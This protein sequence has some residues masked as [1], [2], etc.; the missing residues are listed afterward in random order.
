MTIAPQRAVVA[1]GLT[2]R[3]G[4]VTALDGVDLEI[5]FG[6]V[7]GLLGHNG[8]GKTT[9]V[10]ILTTLLLPTD[11][12]AEV[13][14][15]DVVREPA[16]V[17]E[18]IALAGQ[19]ATL[20]ELLTGRENLVL[21]GCLLGLSRRDAKAR[22]AELLERFGLADAAD[23]VCG[24]YSGGMRRRLDLAACLLVPRPFVVLDEPTT[25]LD[26]ASRIEVWAAV[27]EL[28]DDGTALLLTTQYLE[29]A[30][31]LADRVVVLAGGRVVA[32]GTPSA[33]KDR[34]GGRRVEA[35]LSDAALV[36]AARDALVAAG[37]DAAAEHR[38]CT[39][40]A[41]APR[42]SLD[43]EAALE[44]LRGADIEP[45]EAGL[46]RPTLDDAFLALA[47]EQV[48]DEAVAAS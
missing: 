32:E 22:A 37:L 40:S 6:R 43:L 12:R 27:R 11:G 26:P 29:E 13:C 30:D 1:S 41:P 20:D 46:R 25:G 48:L 5:E 14:G 38:L 39:V 47:G 15:H 3:F 33:M 31:R 44:A 4:D 21:L 36:D 23:R 45:V 2:R 17:R 24:G 35:I 8:A 9:T 28:V 10:N 18:S 7:I 34:V 19:Q 42:G 16:K